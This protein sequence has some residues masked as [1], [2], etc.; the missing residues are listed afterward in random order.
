MTVENDPRTT[1][2]ASA[3]PATSAPSNS[4][5]SHG[6]GRPH[7]DLSVPGA[8]AS[9]EGRSTPPAEGGGKAAS[10][11]AARRW[12]LVAFAV[13]TLVFSVAPVANNLLGKP[14]KDYNL[15]YRTGRTV[16]Q[17]GDIY[18]KDHHLF[19]FM[20]PPSC[21]A[22]LAVASAGGE[23]AMVVGLTL[24]NSAAWAAAVLLAVYLATGR[25]TGQHPLLY[26]VPTLCVVPFI[27]DMYLLGQPNLLL[28]ALMLGAFACL[29]NRRPWSA[30]GLVALA[31]GIKAF[32]VMAVGYLVYRRYWKA[33]AAVVVGLA[34]LLL[35]VPAGY[36]GVGRAYDDLT[37]WT[38]G[39]VLKYD[40]DAIAQRPE[41]CYSF[42]NQS[43]VALGNRLLRPVLADGEVDRQWRVN[44]AALDFRAVNAVI[45]VS[46][47]VLGLAFI[48][49]MPRRDR[50]TLQSDAAEA[51]MLLLLVLLFSPLSFNYSYV[52]LIYPLTVVLHAGLSRPAGSTERALW[53]GWVGVTAAALALA[54]PF[55][56]V[57]Q[58]Y[59]N[60]VLA[61]F[62]LLIALGW[63]TRRSWAP[64]PAS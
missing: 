35:G 9:G 2:S 63:Q 30:G 6:L 44:L 39:M 23:T 31:A 24:V 47:G 25:A 1:P 5:G 26:L 19:P 59:G 20:Y 32:P 13:A 34:V 16:L 28:L 4:V 14:N 56:K 60:L 36:R 22:M 49:C 45:V 55:P 48:A 3:P 46:A 15:W 8:T 18:P 38:R 12:V 21:A 62:L 52:W 41:R 33:T 58:A 50:R 57:A 51:G 11:A 27:H 10:A 17:G 37:T 54:V 29:R 61:A 53:L 42:K 7:L 40:E 64:S 43:I